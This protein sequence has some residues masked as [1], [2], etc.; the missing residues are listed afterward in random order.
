M[1]NHDGTAYVDSWV[2][3]IHKAFARNL[4]NDRSAAGMLQEALPSK[5]ERSITR[6]S[7]REKFLCTIV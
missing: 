7:I 1:G 2:R 3:L 6:W 5:S 4:D